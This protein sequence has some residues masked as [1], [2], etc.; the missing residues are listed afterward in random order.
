MHFKSSSYKQLVRGRGGSGDGMPPHMR[1]FVSPR[2]ASVTKYHTG[3]SSFAHDYIEGAM[4]RM[5]EHPNP[6]M[7]GI[8]RKTIEL[9]DTYT[10][11]AEAD[12][13]R[14]ICC[15]SCSYVVLGTHSVDARLD[16]VLQR[17]SQTVGRLVFFDEAEIAPHTAD[18]LSL[19]YYRALENEYGTG[20]VAGVQVWHLRSGRMYESTRDDVEQTVEEVSSIL[21][22]V[23]S[24]D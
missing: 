20:N 7:R 21:D 24:G 4:S 11:L 1:P 22:E 13:S 6:G 17:N 14:L 2:R 19:P 10:A 16:V 5:L 9:V 15:N 12:G 23:E 8:A 3:G 18:L